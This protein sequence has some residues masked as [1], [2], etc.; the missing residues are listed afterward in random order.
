MGAA[1]YI[2]L[3]KKIDGLD[4][5][6]SGKS[7]SRNMDALDDAARAL[8][9]RPLS[10]FLSMDE[11]ALADLIGELEGSGF[12]LPPIQHF[13]ADEGLAS[14]RALGTHA[15]AQAKGV[16]PDLRECERILSEAAKHGVGW[17]FE[18]DC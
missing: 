5:F 1:F 4:T 6:M 12:S 18:M 9:V 15:A 17:H 11:D 10:E 13:S 14:V 3:E 7:L 8:G 16:G 2:V